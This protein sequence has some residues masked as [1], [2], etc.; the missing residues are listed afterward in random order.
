MEK[1]NP[2]KGESPDRGECLDQIAAISTRMRLVLEGVFSLYDG[3]VLGFANGADEK[4]QR[5]LRR[6]A[7]EAGLFELRDLLNEMQAVQMSQIGR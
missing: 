4:R 6:D 3:G 5:L 2:M 7:L 1:T